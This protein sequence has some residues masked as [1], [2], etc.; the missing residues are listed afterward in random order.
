MNR[1]CEESIAI[2]ISKF[3]A[4]ENEIA[5]CSKHTRQIREWNANVV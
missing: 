1:S 4:D 3:V 5:P 2:V